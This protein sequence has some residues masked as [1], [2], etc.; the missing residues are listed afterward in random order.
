MSGK[1]PA[2]ALSRWVVRGMILVSG[3]LA[4]CSG[5]E[6]GQGSVVPVSQFWRP[7]AAT[8]WCNTHHDPFL[9][10]YTP[11]DPADRFRDRV[12]R[13]EELT[14][15]S[16]FTGMSFDDLHDRVYVTTGKADQANLYAFDMAGRLVWTSDDWDTSAWDPAGPRLDSGAVSGTAI[17]DVDG[18]IYVSDRRYLWSS[19]YEGILRWISPLPPEKNGQ[20]YPFITPFF[21]RT[22]QV[23][24]VTAMGRVAIYDRNSGEIARGNEGGFLLPGLLDVEQ[25]EAPSLVGFLISRLL[26]NSCN[27]QDPYLMDPAMIRAVGEAFVGVGVPVGNSPAVLPDPADPALTRVY[28]AARLRREDPDEAVSVKLFR[29][30]VAWDEA[31]EIVTVKTREGFDGL[32]PGGEGSATS[33]T[34]SR[35]GSTVYVGDNTG[36]FYAFDADDGHRV[37]PNPPVLEGDMLGSPTAAWDDGSIYVATDRALNKLRPN[38][39]ILWSRTFHEYARNE[40]WV[41]KVDRDGDGREDLERVAVPAGLAVASPHRVLMPLTLGYRLNEEMGAA[42]VWPTQAVLAVLDRDGNPAAGPFELPD[43]VETTACATANGDVYV[44]H[45]SSLSSLYNSLYCKLHLDRLGLSLQP[46]IVPVGGLS[47]LRALH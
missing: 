23:G 24:G 14:G 32:M 25:G 22:G 20:T 7:Y 15:D 37:W 36:T 2:R 44:A 11:N 21:T 8:S 29:V 45:A 42:G 4:A 39:E 5:G 31:A 28:V 27:P 18:N 46:P 35:D 17:V 26:W 30:D 13:L 40:E 43:V 47:V 34:I 38:G 9:S 41:K 10:D 19:T 6:G 16:V 33:P 3:W 1:V 12:M